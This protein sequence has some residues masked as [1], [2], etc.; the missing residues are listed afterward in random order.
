MVVSIATDAIVAMLV[1]DVE[2]LWV[3]MFG[4]VLEPS[5]VDEAAGES[6][7]VMTKGVLA[8]VVVTGCSPI[9]LSLFADDVV[10]EAVRAVMG[11]FVRTPS[12]TEPDASIIGR[13]AGATAAGGTG[14]IRPE[15]VVERVDVTGT[16]DEESVL[17]TRIFTVEDDFFGNV[18]STLITGV[19]RDVTFAVLVKF[20]VGDTVDA[21][22]VVSI[23]SECS[24][25][26]HLSRHVR[27]VGSGSAR[28]IID[29]S[30]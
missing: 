10:L 9:V 22:V 28:V 30:F 19:F 8:Y 1:A 25:F 16:A 13:G 11:A 17:T 12:E 6:R 21:V 15:T 29:H 26:L 27:L 14:G 20:V 23:A 18:V 7:A 24:F 3:T 2:G 5:V 4:T